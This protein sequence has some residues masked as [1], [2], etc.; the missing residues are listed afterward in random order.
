M[1]F[2]PLQSPQSSLS[3]LTTI[4]CHL[5]SSALTCF[6]SYPATLLQARFIAMRVELLWNLYRAFMLGVSGGCCPV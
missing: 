5:V 6:S 4:F 2:V 3:I 1:G